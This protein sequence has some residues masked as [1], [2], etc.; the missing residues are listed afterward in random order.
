MA[1]E[2]LPLVQELCYIA[3][4][5]NGINTRRHRARFRK[6]YYAHA[7]EV[8]EAHAGSNKDLRYFEK[9]NDKGKYQAKI[10]AIKFRMAWLKGQNPKPKKWQEMGLHQLRSLMLKGAG[11][12]A[13]AKHETMELSL[14]TTARVKEILSLVRG[15]I[16]YDNGA[17]SII[18]IDG[19]LL[20]SDEVFSYATEYELSLAVTKMVEE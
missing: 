20:R 6:N 14:S 17:I 12:Y 13:M 11:E 5:R 4:K 8:V 2:L 10:N 3:T 19:N 9:H 1:P 18:G 15:V 7:I 16:K